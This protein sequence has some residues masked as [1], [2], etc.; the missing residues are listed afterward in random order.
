MTWTVSA[1]PRQVVKMIQP[2]TIMQGKAMK[3]IMY[4]ALMTLI[5]SLQI[6]SCTR[7][8][9]EI[10]ESTHTMPI[11]QFKNYSFNPAS[12]L[13]SRVTEAPVFVLKHLR[14]LDSRESYTSYIPGKRE[15]EI[16]RQ[17]L[18][19]LPELSKAVLRERLI[20]IYFINNFHGSGLT[21]WVIDEKGE[22]YTYM[23][24]NPD[25]FKYN[26][27]KWLTYRENSCY[28]RDSRDISISVDC[29]TRFNG[30]LYALLHESTHA[31][32]Y[33]KNITPYV[34]ES[35][36]RIGQYRGESTLF[37]RG[38]WKE[39]NKPENSYEFPPRESIT[40]YE[41][42]GPRI[43]ISESIGTYRKLLKTPFVSLYGSLSWA[44]DIAEFVFFHH[45]TEKL[46][47][48][49]RINIRNKK[50]PNFSLE[51]MKSPLVIKRIPSISDFYK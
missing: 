38:T 18:N 14:E 10:H 19:L 13:I 34:E 25:T 47:E 23:V 28:K 3:K 20:A 11:H 39:I 48:P 44:E 37:T 27:S 17:Y 31:V 42:K 26:I 40:F 5:M 41:F 8:T 43:N 24:F 45:L 33:V 50:G 2:V 35:L 30:F 46:K 6:L 1:S 4:T 36:K 15:I 49:Y 29:G 12:T 7:S 32:D 22:F 9:R 51:P 21:D 16:I